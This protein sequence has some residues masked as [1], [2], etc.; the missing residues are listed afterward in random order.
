MNP[1]RT[2]LVKPF[3]RVTRHPYEE[4]YHL[5]LVV[6]ASNGRL[7]GDL[8]IYANAK[9]LTV[10]A[11]A[12]RRF[13]EGNADAVLWELGSELP[14]RRFAF[15]FRLRGL[16]LDER[17]HCALE[18]RFNNNSAPPEREVME[19]SIEAVPSDLDRL[20]GLL[21]EFAKLKHRVLQW[22]VGQ[23]ELRA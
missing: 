22:D 20:A 10:V 1:L 14:E 9:D 15:Y 16:R 3:I 13:P 6:A 5:D 11:D 8:E 21:E 18:L 7:C 19:F 23:G 4:P 12:L 17:G 2:T